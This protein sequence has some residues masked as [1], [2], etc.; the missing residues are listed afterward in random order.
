LDENADDSS[1]LEESLQ[2]SEFLLRTLLD[3]IPDSIYFKDRDSRFIQISQSMA[4]KFN[5]ADRESV[6]GKSDVD[7]FS[8]EHAEKVAGSAR[9]VVLHHQDAAYR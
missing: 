2:D 6:I 8:H 1:Q 9:Y 5:F 3:S 7:I 4:R